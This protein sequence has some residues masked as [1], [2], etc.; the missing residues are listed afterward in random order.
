LPNL[1]K[2]TD[3]GPQTVDLCKIAES[4]GHETDIEDKTER[5][6]RLLVIALLL[7]TVAGNAN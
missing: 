6:L 2:S 4:A 7:L 1:H 5:L 3:S